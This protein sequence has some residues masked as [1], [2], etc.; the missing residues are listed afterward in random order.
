MNF[1]LT[2][3]TL[4]AWFLMAQ[5]MPT[6]NWFVKVKS[7]FPSPLTFLWDAWAGCSFCG[8]FWIALLLK[9][10]T[11]LATVPELNHLHPLLAFPLDALVTTTLGS[12]TL[13]LTG[14]LNLLLTAARNRQEAENRKAASQQTSA[15]AAAPVAS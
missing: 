2:I 3:M 10:I 5:K 12:L 14:P 8:G 9:S 13:N 6:W 15:V 4:G 11:G 7:W 1:A